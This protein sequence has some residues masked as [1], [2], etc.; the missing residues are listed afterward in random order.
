MNT[1]H[2]KS[3]ATA[4]KQA[5]ISHSLLILTCGTY[6]NTVRWIPPLNVSVE[7]VDQALQTFGHPLEK[8]R[9]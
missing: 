8:V 5:C 4:V 3:I 6:S 7:Q 9:A 2:G 1:D